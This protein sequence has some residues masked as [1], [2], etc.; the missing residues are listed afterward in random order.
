VAIAGRDYCVIAS[1]SRL[2]ESYMIRS[3][4]VNILGDSSRFYQIQDVS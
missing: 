2:S 1:D 4:E 3:R